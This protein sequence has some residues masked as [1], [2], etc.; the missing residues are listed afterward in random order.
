MQDF[1]W[2]GG[3]INEINAAIK[4]YQKHVAAVMNH[5]RIIFR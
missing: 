4:N 3:C 5:Y 1:F 2:G